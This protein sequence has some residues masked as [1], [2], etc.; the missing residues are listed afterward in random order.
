MG[1]PVRSVSLLAYVLHTSHAYFVESRA[2][3]ELAQLFGSYVPPELVGEMNENP[4]QYSMSAKSTELTVM[5]ADVRG[6]T[7]LSEKMEPAALA[8]LMA[9]A[10]PVRVLQE[11]RAK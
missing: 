9:R 10:T 2:K 6:F 1:P 5:F 3:R 7:T 4:A 11:L 8:R